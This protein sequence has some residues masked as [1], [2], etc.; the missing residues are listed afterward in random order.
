MFN[1]F[2]RKEEGYIDA[3]DLKAALTWIMD[4]QPTEERENLFDYFR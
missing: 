2:D 3:F 4:K 1:I